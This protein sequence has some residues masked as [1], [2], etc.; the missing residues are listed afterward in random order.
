MINAETPWQVLR[1]F[2]MG[3]ADVVPGVSG[4]TV[5]LVFGIYERLVANIR[6]AA[7][8]AGR[9]VKGDVSG[10][11]AEL[12]AVEW[13]FLI[14]LGVG[15]LVAVATLARLIETALEDHPIPMTALFLGLVAASAVVAARLVESWTAQRVAL[16]AAVAVVLFFVLGL[17]SGERVDPPLLLFLGAGALAI[18]A[19]ILPGVSGSFLLLTVGMYEPVLD[20]VN[21]RDLVTIAV[22]GVGCVIGLGLFSSAL[23]WSLE[24]HHDTV[25]AALVGLMIGSLRVLWPWPEGVE[26]TA[27]EA[28]GDDLG[29][30][31]VIALAAA[32]VV[33]AVSRWA[34]S[35]S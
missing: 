20:A 14:P 2:V 3:A 11:T 34:E 18:C 7:G 24:N 5:A 25:M 32:A 8:A 27:L 31:I 26:E 4:G 13:T 9:L 30:A 12:K 16:M 17:Q 21:D 28:P 29:L 10:F 23:H 6:R 1:G 22:V 19:M 15:I 35:R 33:L